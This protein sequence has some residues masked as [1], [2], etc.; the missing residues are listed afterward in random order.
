MGG[1][2][3]VPLRRARV[4]VLFAL[5]KPGAKPNGLQYDPAARRLLVADQGDGALVPVDDPR[6]A[7]RP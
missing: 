5:A 3:H 1:L 4:E 6:G 2:R 7:R